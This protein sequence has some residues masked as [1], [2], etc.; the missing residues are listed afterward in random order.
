VKRGIRRLAPTWLT[1]ITRALGS[2]SIWT[3]AET[4]TREETDTI[5]FS[6]ARS[7]ILIPAALAPTE[8]E[9]R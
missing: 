6:L 3:T 2:T 5:V 4:S 9:D 8:S 1:T 7:E